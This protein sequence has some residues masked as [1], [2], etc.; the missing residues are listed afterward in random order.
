MKNYA[1]S[2]TLAISVL[3]GLLAQWEPA[4]E[5]MKDSPELVGLAVGLV[6]AVLRLVT[7]KQLGKY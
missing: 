4:Q 1:E 7:T 2:K 6:F 3:T 5:V